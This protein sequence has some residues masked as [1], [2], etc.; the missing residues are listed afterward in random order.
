[1]PTTWWCAQC[2]NL[3]N[4][5][6]GRMGIE[7][8]KCPNCGTRSIIQFASVFVC[9]SCHTIAPLEPAICPDCHDSRAVIL[10]G[11]G[12]RRREYRWRCRIHPEFELYVRKN[13]NRDGAR[14]ALK[15]TG[16]RIYYPEQIRQVSSQILG[17][18]IKRE[19]GDL[20]F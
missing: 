2:E 20:H 17:Q 10:E 11:R 5:P 13:C 4:G 14:M 16:G 3:F 1:N 15:A 19:V 6:V 9:P 12:G 7:D 18:G 8:G